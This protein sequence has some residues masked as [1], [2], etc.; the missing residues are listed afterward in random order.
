[1]VLDDFIERRETPV[2]EAENRAINAYI[3]ISM[4][5]NSWLCFLNLV[6]QEHCSLVVQSSDP[7]YPQSR[8]D[9]P[10]DDKDE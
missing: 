5:T 7:G 8:L 2:V 1:M 4:I 3:T 6:L 10:P 9:L